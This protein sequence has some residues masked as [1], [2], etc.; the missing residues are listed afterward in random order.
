MENIVETLEVSM[1]VII[2]IM[3]MVFLLAMVNEY[4][5]NRRND[6]RKDAVIEVE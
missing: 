3:A 5:D 4:T 6:Y 2:F 1:S